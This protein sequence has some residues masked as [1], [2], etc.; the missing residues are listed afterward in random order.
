MENATM[1]TVLLQVLLAIMTVIASVSAAAAQWTTVGS[2]G[3]VDEADV[4]EFE[5]AASQV[6]IR[7]T[8]AV[9]ATVV[10]RYNVVAIPESGGVGAG[11]TVRYLDNADGAR[12]FSVLKQVNITTG[13]TTNVFALDSNAFPADSAFQTRSV[14]DCDLSLDF[15]INAY[16]IETTLT[17]STPAASPRLQAI[18]LTTAACR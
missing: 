8:A 2:A 14:F 12:V 17:K 10:I 11:M 16:F 18:R 13:V 5:T 9:P 6:R 15:S 3:T 1:K 7:S 4:A